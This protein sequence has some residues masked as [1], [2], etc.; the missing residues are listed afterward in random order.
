M[1][2]E[3][4]RHPILAPMFDIEI[5]FKRSTSYFFSMLDTQMSFYKSTVHLIIAPD[6]FPRFA[7]TMGCEQKIASCDL[8]LMNRPCLVAF[9][10][11]FFLYGSTTKKGGVLTECLNSEFVPSAY[12]RMFKE[13]PS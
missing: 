10:Y 3:L 8:L 1:A 11:S 6:H 13:G 2:S 5:S 12:C 9:S 4:V 7:L